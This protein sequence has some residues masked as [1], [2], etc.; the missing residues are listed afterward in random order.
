MN[1]LVSRYSLPLLLMLLL[2]LFIPAPS[3]AKLTET[4]VN[5]NLYCA[6]CLGEM[7]LA[8]C[9][10]RTANQMRSVVT[11]MLNQGKS[12]QEILDYF[13]AQYGESILTLIPKKGFNIVAYLGPIIGLLVG[14]PVA[15]LVIRRWGSTGGDA[16]EGGN[17]GS[18]VV[19]DEQTRQKIEQELT[20][21][22][23]ED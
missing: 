12:K 19:L 17:A 11:Q 4:E 14:I 21:L 1:Q 13:V 22:D 3:G 23:E 2:V 18:S 15:I 20:A 6:D 16:T 5:E 9:N 7:D 8:T 10:D